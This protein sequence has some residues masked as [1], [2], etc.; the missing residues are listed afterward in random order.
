MASYVDG[1]VSF[2]PDGISMNAYMAIG[3]R[4]GGEVIQ[5]NF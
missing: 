4:N 5:G 2:I 1:H 3:S